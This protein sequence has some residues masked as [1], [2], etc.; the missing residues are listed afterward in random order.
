M[1]NRIQGLLQ[2]GMAFHGKRQLIEAEARYRDVL[3]IDPENADAIYLLGLLAEAIGDRDLAV[4]L[5][6]RAI[7]IQ[8][9]NPL[10]H[11]A[12][13]SLLKSQGKSDLATGCFLNALKLDPNHM[14]SLIGLANL[15]QEAGKMEEAIS[16][17]RRGLAIAPENAVF[18]ENLAQTLFNLGLRLEN[19]GLKD[20]A[21]LCYKESLFLSPSLTQIK[22][23]I[24]LLASSPANSFDERLR[25]GLRYHLNGQ[26]AEAADCYREAAARNPG[27]AMALELLELGN[28]ALEDI[29]LIAELQSGSESSITETQSASAQETD[30]LISN[31]KL[32]LVERKN[33]II[34][35]NDRIRVLEA[36]L[37]AV[38]KSSSKWNLVQ[39][40]HLA[41]SL[42]KANKLDEARGIEEL[43]LE[44][45][46]QNK[47]AI[48]LLIDL[49]VIYHQRH[50]LNTAASIYRIILEKDS[51]NPKIYH[52]LGLIYGQRG[53]H[54][55]SL[56]LIEKSIKYAANVPPHFFKNAGQVA[57]QLGDLAKAEDYFRQA[58][59]KDA[60]FPDGYLCLSH[61]L[62]NRGRFD[63]AEKCLLLGLE[64]MPDNAELANQ[65]QYLNYK[66]RPLTH[67]AK[68]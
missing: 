31:L 12:L 48:A 17:Y 21:I 49:G 35:L 63:E 65:L 25:Q 64:K 13:A 16:L 26:F 56:G 7:A 52:L 59:A 9:T 57:E 58:I 22:E 42:Q 62:E 66:A 5:V 54:A 20:K 28:D 18:K 45:Q 8:P 40:L 24:D 14:D 51:N 27:N 50:D 44:L 68:T 19:Q 33:Q 29:Q 61:L 36:Q 60:S 11:S 39:A 6:S 2:E 43:A 37:K 67:I 10:F 34:E 3:Q 1:T 4:D 53:Q 23:R 55:E 38:V 41:E 30:E 47:S 32:D 46:P 15:H